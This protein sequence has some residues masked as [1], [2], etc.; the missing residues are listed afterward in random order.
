VTVV[1]AHEST[2]GLHGNPIC[3][4]I[5]VVIAIRLQGAGFLVGAAA[6]LVLMLP[7]PDAGA[8]AYR[9]PGNKIF[10]GV[11]D[12]GDVGAYD[13][14]RRQ[15]RAHSALLQAFYHWDTPLRSSGAFYRWEQTN[16]L[17]VV[18]LSNA[19]PESGG[20]EVSPGAIA[21]GK[22]DHY[23][24]RLN[25]S[26]GNW[27]KRVY[28][29]LFPEMNGHWNPYCAF[30][31]NGSRRDG[32]HTTKDF[33]RAWRRIVIIVRGGT[34][35][36]VNK[37]L[38][39]QHMPRIYGAR[40]N[41]DPIYDD[42]EKKV[43]AVME[44]PKVAFMWV[45]QTFGSPN[46]RG[47]QPQDYFP[48][49]KYVDWVG[50]DIF[51]KFSGAFDE[52]QDFYRRWDNWPFVIGEYSPWDGDPGG[53]FTKRLFRW[54]LDKGRVRALIYYRSV[55]VDNEYAIDRYPAARKVLRRMLNKGRFAKFGPG[56]R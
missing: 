31:A 22:G 5:E 43:P 40:S 10:H 50:A 25:E 56:A 29:R 32:N 55:T 26:I 17:G 30:N 23:L 39:K 54:A 1:G 9:P 37:R 53:R 34:R 12:T 7:A 3:R 21:R 11:S 36:K 28:I 27:E 19:L 16:T 42:G 15:V 14:F 38:R 6:A 4:I 35:A 8:N 24:V 44:R 18:S 47:N 45:P 2:P 52:L 41:G 20:P 49:G 33:R 51:S 48:G 46:R 13:S